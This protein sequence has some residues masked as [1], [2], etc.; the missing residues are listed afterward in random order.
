MTGNS[1]RKDAL[2][3]VALFITTRL[4]IQLRGVHFGFDALYDYWQYLDVQS[5]RHHLLRG[6]WY[7]HSQ[8]PVFNLFLGTVL[9]ISGSAAPLVLQVIFLMMS[10]V[11]AWL[12]LLIVKLVTSSRSLALA[13]SL[14]YLVSPAT[15]LFEN[16][17]FYTSFLSLW[18]L[19]AVYAV[20]LFERRKRNIYLVIFYAALCLLCLTRS[21]Y[22]ITWLAGLSLFLT[23]YYRKTPFFKPVFIS[24]LVSLCLVSGWY[25]KNAVIFGKFAASS[26]MGINF[27][28]IV[29]HDEAITDSSSIAAIHPFYPI[30]YYRKYITRD[31]E[32]YAGLDDRDLLNEIKNDHFVNMNHAG[33]LQVS[34]K[35]MAASW[36]Y[37]AKHPGAYLRNMG[38]S[39]IIFFTPASSYFKLEQN[40]EHIRHYDLLAGFNLSHLSTI[41]REKKTLLAMAAIPM[42][43]LYAIVFIFMVRRGKWNAANVF[44]ATTIGFTFIAGTLLEY[45]ENMRYRYEIQPLFFVL[46][47]QV[48]NHRN[49]GMHAETN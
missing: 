18:L 41:D 8:P 29:F 32:R 46:L 5:L 7:Q 44:I 3:L 1:N 47:S 27:S 40:A 23:W 24:A 20:V 31:Y 48:L 28:R 42:C 21:M 16:E 39:F 15:M 36:S 6:L 35:Y 38:K 22:H 49:R 11:N 2:I 17:L 10:F 12:L 34:D 37:L 25:A 14:G 33:Y 13:F 19:V 45:G 30:S 43:L 26:W 4:L 9:K